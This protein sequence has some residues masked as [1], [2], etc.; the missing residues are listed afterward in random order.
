MNKKRWIAV[1]VLIIILIILAFFYDKKDSGPENT[2]TCGNNGEFCPGTPGYKERIKEEFKENKEESP[3]E[4]I[5]YKP[6]EVKSITKK[7]DSLWSI[8]IDLLTPNPSWIPGDD[9]TGGPFINQNS[10][11]RVLNVTA[12]TKTY[13]CNTNS[14]PDV[15]EDTS[16]FIDEI[17]KG[18]YKIRYFDTYGSDIT[19]IYKQCL[20]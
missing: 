5:A 8:S 20:P 17:E 10:R 13:S 12:Q 7:S 1:I 15:V 14:Y 9:S 11:I 18:S 19:S 6:A 4:V 16:N 3:E 2:G